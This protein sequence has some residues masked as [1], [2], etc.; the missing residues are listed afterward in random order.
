V[1]G[2]FEALMAEA[3]AGAERFGHR[4]HV[5]LTWLAVT[6]HGAP[7]AL[8]L[9][10]GGIRRAAP[11]MYHA[12]MTRAWVE[13]V[14]RHAAEVADPDVDA[15]LARCPDL[16]DKRLLDRHYRP[17]TLAALAARAGWVSPDLRPI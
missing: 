15:F 13:I 3:I 4:E 9:I 6:R 7:D 12:T 16:L 17:A 5:R 10:G 2:R 8:A 11:A 1:S 14:A